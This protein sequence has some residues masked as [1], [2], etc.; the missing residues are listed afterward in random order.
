MTDKIDLTLEH[1]KVLRAESKQTRDDLTEIKHHVIVV[2]NQ[3]ADMLKEHVLLHERLASHELRI[4]RIE[5][6]LGLLD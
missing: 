3:M 1:M 6:R 5:K 4:E 2:R